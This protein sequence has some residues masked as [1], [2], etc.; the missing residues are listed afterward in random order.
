MFLR[1][2]NADSLPS[3]ATG[4]GTLS[5]RES[6]AGTGKRSIGLA[7][8]VLATTV[9]FA[10]A[11]F[12]LDAAPSMMAPSSLQQAFESCP[13]FREANFWGE[14]AI[15]LINHGHRGLPDTQHMRSA[16]V[17]PSGLCIVTSFAGQFE[18]LADVTGKNFDL[19]ARK[20]NY[21]FI[22]DTRFPD[23]N[24]T[25][26]ENMQLDFLLHVLEHRSTCEWLFWVSP[27]S[28]FHQMDV[29]LD[30]FVQDSQADFVMTWEDDN[31]ICDVAQS[32]HVKIHTDYSFLRPEVANFF[33][34]NSAY[35]RAF[36]TEARQYTQAAR[37]LVPYWRD[38]GAFAETVLRR[39]EDDVKAGHYEFYN[40][41]AFNS[42]C[43]KGNVRPCNT[44]DF[45]LHRIAA[46][47]K[48]ISDAKAKCRQAMQDFFDQLGHTRSGHLDDI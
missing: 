21:Q 32:P 8:L 31:P 6:K 41:R 26:W 28:V 35:A 10:V 17:S 34:R 11:W 2:P 13:S 43:M 12:I 4:E 24:S 9:I 16:A 15:P 29:R 22:T 48:T 27:D 23:W 47:P 1:R 45:V 44:E 38:Q 18:Q 14:L 37:S 7:S 39:A 42:R 36:L 20:H 33:V 46:C 30:L 19:Y 3:F 25:A 5:P 40:L